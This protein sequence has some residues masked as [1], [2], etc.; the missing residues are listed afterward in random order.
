MTDAQAVR[1]VRILKLTAQALEQPWATILLRNV[2]KPCDIIIVRVGVPH[3]WKDIGDEVIYLSFRPARQNANFALTSTRRS[4][5]H[6]TKT[7]PETTKRIPR[8]TEVL[9]LF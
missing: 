9:K 8:P 1:P 5:N 3:G 4:N 6:F 7:A 2:A